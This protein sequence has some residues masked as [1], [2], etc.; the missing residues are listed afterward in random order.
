MEPNFNAV[1]WV[2]LVLTLALVRYNRVQEAA[3]RKPAE[4]TSEESTSDARSFESFR[5]RYLVVYL[6]MVAG[7]WLQGPYVYS[8]YSAY[9]FSKEEISQLFVVGFGASMVFGTFI[10]SMADSLGRKKFCLLYCALYVASCLTK[11]VN[12]YSVLMLG[13]LLGGTATSL[14]FSVFESWL[15]CAH[16]SR[17]FGEERLGAMFSLSILGNSVVAI[18]SGLLAQA[19]ADAVPITGGPLLFVG[20]NTAPFDLASIVLVIGGC[21]LALTWEENYGERQASAFSSAALVASIGVLRKNPSVLALG[22]VQ[23]LFEGAM[24]SFVFEWT[25]A[26][27]KEEGSTLPY[28][29]IFATFMVCCMAGSQLVPMVLARYS[30]QQALPAVFVVSAVALAAVPLDDVL[31]GALAFYGFLVFELCVGLYFPLMGMLK[32]QVVP[33]QHRSTLYNLFRVPLN[34]IV[35]VVLLRDFSV[36]FTFALCV[37]LL[38]AAA[39]LTVFAAHRLRVDA[40][41]VAVKGPDED[42]MQPL[43]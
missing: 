32:S 12:D 6:L 19:A 9:G 11:H 28:G 38:L 40:G 4:T 2:T 7:D 27:T 14:L 13:R 35:L 8:L 25:P 43:N 17:G 5:S 3:A 23:S 20:G 41:A 22:L 37:A 30:P 24:Y 42:E 21:V 10:G 18:A 1:F 34:V 39:A 31:G 29:T 15:V 33:E 36:P 26:L 16:N